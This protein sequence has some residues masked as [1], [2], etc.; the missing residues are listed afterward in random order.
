MTYLS[1]KKILKIFEKLEIKVIDINKELFLNLKNKKSLFPF[2]SFGHYNEKG[3]KMITNIINE[4][5]FF[6]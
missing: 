5:I 1:Y 6:N 4:K 2:E 3:Y